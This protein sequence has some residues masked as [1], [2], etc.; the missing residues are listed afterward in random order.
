LFALQDEIP[1]R[2]AAALDRELVDAEASR[3]TE[4][5]DMRDHILRGRAF[6]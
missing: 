2:I 3:P 5:P 6:G 1:S 4:H